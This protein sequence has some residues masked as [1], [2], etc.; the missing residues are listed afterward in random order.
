MGYRIGGR[1]WE[2][3]LGLLT[4]KKGQRERRARGPARMIPEG[5]KVGVHHII[6]DALKISV[7]CGSKIIPCAVPDRERGACGVRRG[8]GRE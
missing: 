3:G 5:L 7:T 1:G 4:M 6:T 8:H 2:M